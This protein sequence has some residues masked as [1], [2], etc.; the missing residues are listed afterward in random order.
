MVCAGPGGH[1]DVRAPCYSWWL[2]WCPW[3]MMLPQ[4]VFMPVVHVDISGLCCQLEL[5][6]SS[7]IHAVVCVATCD[8]VMLM[9][10]FNTTGQMDVC[11]LSCYLKPCRCVWFMLPPSLLWTSMNCAA[12][13][14]YVD[15]CGL[16][17]SCAPMLPQG[18]MLMPVDCAATGGAA[19][20]CK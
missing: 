20:D 6:L 15:V 5:M 12:T 8:H 13:K 9:V 18:A 7:M 17:Y 3:S 11:G 2:C 19:A 1:V 4:T 14:G 16:C 10:C